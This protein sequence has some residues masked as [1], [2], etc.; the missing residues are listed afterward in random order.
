MQTF[1]EAATVA[2]VWVLVVLGLGV[3]LAGVVMW[4]WNQV[5]PDVFGLKAITFWQ[6]L[7]LTWLGTML[8]KSGTP[9]SDKS[10]EHLERIKQLQQE[11][12]RLLEQ[13]RDQQGMEVS[14]LDDVNSSLRDVANTLER[15]R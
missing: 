1:K 6:A 12:V 10:G 3:V 15:Q 2:A 13:M 4:L 9:S 11:Q 5:V 8:F 14:S 7:C